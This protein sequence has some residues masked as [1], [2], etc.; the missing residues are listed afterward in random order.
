MKLF[1]SIRRKL[2]GTGKIK[3]YLIYALGE[4]LLIVIGI[5]IA[6]K[7]NSLNEINKNRIVEV[8]IYESLFEELHT[9]LNALDSAIVRYDTNALTLQSSLQFIGKPQIELTQEMKNLIIQTKFKNTNL[10]DA[11]LNS[12]NNTNKFEFL[13]N[14]S[15]KELIALYPNE[16]S[17]F[18]NQE[19]KIGNIVNNRLQPVIEKHISLLDLLPEEN[20]KYNQLKNL[21]Q[22]SNYLDLLNSREYQ[23]CLIDQLLQT[24]IQLNMA[25][26]LRTKTERLAVK[27][28]LEL[29][30]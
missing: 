11:A 4:I 1:R 23:N 30:R 18:K 9:N 15:L 24:Q 7:I 12:I 26:S 27:L 19:I 20:K 8:K 28:K 3:S 25:K 2:I 5:L 21:G 6:W 10:R 17:I 16:I 22:Q 13:E 29:K 14:D